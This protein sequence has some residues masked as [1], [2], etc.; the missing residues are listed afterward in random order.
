MPP[1]T[2]LAMLSD[3]MLK[4]KRERDTAREHQERKHKTWDENYELYR[5]K[6]RTNRLTQ[7]QTVNLPLMKETIKTILSKIDDPPQID[8]KEKSS[9]EM[10]ELIFQEI[11]NTQFRDQKLEWLD[12]LDKKNVLLYGISTKFLNPTD[13][14]V[15]ISVLDVFDVVFDPLIARLTQ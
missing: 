4:L 8:W 9:D 15:D 12:I 13:E 1:T 11:W 10:K 14:T 3:K 6:V 2:Q 7:R 5:N